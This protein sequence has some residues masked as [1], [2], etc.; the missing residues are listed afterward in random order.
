MTIKT[1][2]IVNAQQAETIKKLTNKYES[3]V[4]LL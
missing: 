2:Q 1:L 3:L 4:Q